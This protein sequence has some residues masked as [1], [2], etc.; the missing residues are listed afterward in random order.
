[1]K[2]QTGIGVIKQIAWAALL[3]SVLLLPAVTHALS[4]GEA[5]RKG[6][7]TETGNGYLRAQKGSGD[8]KEL[9]RRTNAARKAKYRQIAN[10]LKVGVGV[11]EKDFGKKLGGR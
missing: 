8:V 2:K 6:L 7:V 3:T 4:V 11:V 5:K 10:D 1:M 9:V